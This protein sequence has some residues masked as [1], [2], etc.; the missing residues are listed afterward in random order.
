M[1]KYI[2]Y[3]LL[4]A[5]GLKALVYGLSW[6]S[7]ACLAALGTICFLIEKN[8]ESSALKE[9]REKVAAQDA[10]YQALKT[11]TEQVKSF[12]TSIK[13]NSMRPAGNGFGR[14]AQQ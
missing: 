11:D 9:L 13:L 14:P 6:E 8:I 2:P 5:F 7:V 10:A 1:I 4:T 12:V 3:G